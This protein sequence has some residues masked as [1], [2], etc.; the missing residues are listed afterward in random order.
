VT[1]RI[2]RP[3]QPSSDVNGHPQFRGQNASPL[4]RVNPTVNKRKYKSK[5]TGLSTLSHPTRNRAM[6][7][8]PAHNADTLPDAPRPHQHSHSNL[9][10]A[11]FSFNPGNLYYLRYKRKQS[12]WDRPG[13]RTNRALIESSLALSRRRE[14][15][16][17]LRSGPHMSGT[18]TYSMLLALRPHGPTPVSPPPQHVHARLRTLGL[19]TPCRPVWSRDGD[20]RM[21]FVR[22]RGCRAG[23]RA[24]RKQTLSADQ[25]SSPAPSD[26]VSSSAVLGCLNV[27]S[28]LRKYD[29][30]IELCRLLVFHHPLSLS[31]QT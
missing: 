29:D 15:D 14:R 18:A 7:A 5:S 12:F 9:V 3:L 28:L 19:W 23:R 26:H 8:G 17:W 13:L 20:P 4:K 6:A 31:F 25:P 11:F 1:Y 27:R 30:V 21:R 24:K 2:P 10:L 22:R 16:S